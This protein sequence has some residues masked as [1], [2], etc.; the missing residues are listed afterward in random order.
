MNNIQRIIL[1]RHCTPEIPNISCSAKQAQYY[2][3]EYDNT[4]N[5]RLSEIELFSS[6]EILN[7]IKKCE[8]VY[9]SPLPR[10]KITANKLFNAGTIS[11]CDELKEFNLSIKNIPIISLPVQSWFILSRLLWLIGLNKC[12]YNLSQE[13]HRIKTFIQQLLI[14]KTCTA[15]VAHGFVIR[16]LKRYFLNQHFRCK[17]YEKQGC[18]SVVI[19]ERSYPLGAEN[20]KYD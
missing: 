18:F 8:S 7:E 16:E 1:I 2:L 17:F 6:Q 5:I 9:C 13:K 20:T 14:E 15:I 19:L 10:A 12:Q 3:K 4:E 11:Y